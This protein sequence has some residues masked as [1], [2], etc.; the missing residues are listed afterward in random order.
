MSRPTRAEINLQALGENIAHARQLAAGSRLMAVVKAN[1]YGHGA[2]TVASEADSQVDAFAVAC[3]EEALEL[4]AGGISSPI[5]LLEGVF[6]P[7][8]LR[9]AAEHG[10]WITVANELQLRW[11]EE[12]D[13]ENAPHSWLKVNTGMNRLGVST[14]DAPEFYQR[15]KACTNN[16][17]VLYTHFSSADNLE[18]AV[19]QE[20]LEHFENLP[21]DALRSAANSAGLLAWPQSHYDWV[22]PGYMLYGNSPL[23]EAHPNANALKSVMSL[24][25]SVISVNEVESGAAVGYGGSFV[26][27]R[28]SRIA[29][30]AAGYADGYP[31]NAPSGTPVLIH[32]TKAPLAGRVSMDMIT[33]DVTDMAPIDIGTEVTLWGEGLSVNEIARLTG[34]LGYE[35]TTRMPAR[36]PRIVT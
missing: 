15:L 3:L 9:E 33:V 14:E 28:P 21:I 19:T 6:D 8:E 24:K 5:L 29:T 11:L 20:Q 10:L 4:R 12:S 30:I 31:R 35:L 27:R 7:G 22:R 1:A 2:V 16:A 36:P 23:E 18:S 34:T 25:S 17:P 13:T 32:G 26:T